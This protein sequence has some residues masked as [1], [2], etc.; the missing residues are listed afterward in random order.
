VAGAMRGDD[1]GDGFGHLKLRSAKRFGR[2]LAKAGCF[3]T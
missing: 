2:D 1:R 3:L